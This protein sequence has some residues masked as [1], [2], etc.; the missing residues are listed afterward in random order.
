[1]KLNLYLLMGWL[2]ASSN[3]SWA[4]NETVGF[5]KQKQEGSLVYYSGSVVLEGEFWYPIVEGERE[6]VGDQLCFTVAEKDAKLIPRDQDD[7]RSPWFC[8]KDTKQSIEQLGLTEF[9]KLKACEL[10]GKATLEVTNYVVD[11]EQ[12]ETNDRAR[13]VKVIKQ[14]ETVTVKVLY[15]GG[16]ACED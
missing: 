12:T 13:L 15:V 16:G 9:A 14:P 7:T 6:V 1:M 4:A 5:I 10:R 3:S 8:F 2:A 11:K